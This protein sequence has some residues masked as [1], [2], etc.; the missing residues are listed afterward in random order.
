MEDIEFNFKINKIPGDNEVMMSQNGQYTAE[1]MF[2][3]NYGGVYLYS[4]EI[5]RP[6]SE[7]TRIP[8]SA[9][10]SGTSGE[11][12]NQTIQI[13]WIKLQSQQ[14]P[15]KIVRP[16]IKVGDNI[17]VKIT[18]LHKPAYRYQLGNT[19]SY[20]YFNS[21]VITIG[22]NVYTLTPTERTDN[23]ISGA[24]F[25]KRTATGGKRKIKTYRR[26]RNNRKSRRSIKDKS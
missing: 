1:A 17:N 8:L 13:D 14:P 24:T 3:D 23:R 5:S 12:R 22:N 21:C 6:L 25:D 11:I 4:L 18:N 2:Q 10:H 15:S 20:F 19:D 9:R 26:K 16:V 7:G